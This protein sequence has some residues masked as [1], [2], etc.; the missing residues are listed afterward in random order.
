[1]A[2]PLAVRLPNWVGDVCMALPALHALHEAG[3]TLHCLGK[4]W[5]PALLAGC[6]WQTSPLPK[7]IRAGGRAL[8]DT[9]AT[10]ALLFPN[11][12]SSALQARLAG[13]ESVGYRGDWR[14]PLLS[15]ALPKPKA[16]QGHEVERMYRLA[17]AA[18]QRW[19]WSLPD[20]AGPLRLPLTEACETRVTA[21]LADQGI[22]GPYVLLAP[23]AAGTIRGHDKR[24]PGFPALCR[25][26]LDQGH[27]V[28]GAPGPGED[29][30]TA[31]RLPGA[32]ILPDLDLAALGALARSARLVVANDSGPMH[33]A[34]A[35]G[36]NVLGVFGGGEPWRTSPWGAKM[37][38]NDQGWPPEDAVI[39]RVGA[40]LP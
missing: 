33:L 24:W 4:G 3:A 5:A 11:S 27:V 39:R 32:R 20:Q 23:L 7:G 36:A 2:E 29:E 6:P 10:R 9:G 17:Q 15:Q 31:A 12:A 16:G 26:L 40:M 30:E 1:M 22:D 21:A 25:A 19:Q 8:A 13:L 14:S 28:V 37:I 38:G 35:V 34:A 18:A